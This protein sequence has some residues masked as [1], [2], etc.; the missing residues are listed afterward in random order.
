[1]PHALGC[2]SVMIDEED[3]VN[4]KI[5]ISTMISPETQ[6]ENSAYDMLNTTEIPSPDLLHTAVDESF[7]K[8]SCL[9]NNAVA[10]AAQ[11]AFD[12]RVYIIWLGWTRIHLCR[13]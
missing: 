10:A 4:S 7:M 8:S 9:L 1:M 3:H 13:S 12:R 5:Q 6:I 2:K 11:D